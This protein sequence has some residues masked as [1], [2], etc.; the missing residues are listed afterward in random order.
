MV[1][2]ALHDQESP[3]TVG[4]SDAG[5]PSAAVSNHRLRPCSHSTRRSRSGSG[6]ATPGATEL[7]PESMLVDGLQPT[8]VLGGVDVAASSGAASTLSTLEVRA[9]R[10]PV[11]ACA[12]A[13]R[14]KRR[15]PV[16]N[17]G[18]AGGGARARE[19]LVLAD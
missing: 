13:P 10:R 11:L 4:S 18:G 7:P 1:S 12:R 14:R 19:A 3:P 2:A 8:R 17:A 6:V 9:S 16:P 5:E 15:N